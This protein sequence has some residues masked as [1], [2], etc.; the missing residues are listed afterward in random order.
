[1]KR[2]Y[3]IVEGPHEVAAVGRL[4]SRRNLKQVRLAQDLDVHFLDLVPKVFPGI[5]GDL[6]AR[7]PVPAFFRSATHSVVVESAIGVSKIAATFQARSNLELE[8]DAVGILA[9]ADTDATRCRQKIANS[10]PDLD[11]GSAA[12][13]IGEGTPRAGIFVLPDNQT[14]GAL[15]HLL[16][17]CGELVYPDLLIPVRELIERLD[18][19]DSTVFANGKERADLAKPFGRHKATVACVGNILRPG[20]AIQVSIQD[21]RWLRDERVFEEPTVKALADFIDAVLGIGVEE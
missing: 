1:M 4:L 12:D 17:R 2:A 9:D 13:R 10:L 11:F 14:P 3:F 21:N 16:L 15:E 8:L 6:L 18:P 5:T 7:V 20:K 19:D